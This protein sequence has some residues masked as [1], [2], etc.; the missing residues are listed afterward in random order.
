MQAEYDEGIVLNAQGHIG[1]RYDNAMFF[2]NMDAR[3]EYRISHYEHDT[4]L[5]RFTIALEHIDSLM[6]WPVTFEADNEQENEI[7]RSCEMFTEYNKD[8]IYVL[9]FN[10]RKEFCHEVRKIEYM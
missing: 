8:E 9:L 10:W 2:L 4:P 3:W 6:L 1:P 7:F 5:N